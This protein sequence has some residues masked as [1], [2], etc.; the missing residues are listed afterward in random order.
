MNT[1]RNFLIIFFPNLFRVKIEVEGHTD[2]ELAF[3]NMPLHGQNP[4]P[5]ESTQKEVV[6]T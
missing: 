6:K 2:E 3:I 4:D 1:I 5:I